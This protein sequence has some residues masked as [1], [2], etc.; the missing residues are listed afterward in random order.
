M[1]G[2]W[3]PKL[4]AAFSSLR[5]HCQGGESFEIADWKNDFDSTY[6]TF[7]NTNALSN[8]ISKKNLF[9]PLEIFSSSVLLNEIFR[10]CLH[11]SVTKK[12]TEKNTKKNKRQNKLFWTDKNTKSKEKDL[13]LLRLNQQTKIFAESSN[14]KI[15]K[16]SQK[17]IF[18]FALRGILCF[19]F[20]SLN[21]LYE[22]EK[23][24]QQFY[25]V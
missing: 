8:S 19:L 9:F 4:P 25:P 22:K 7:M 16:K 2:N 14:L 12:A 20:Y 24:I 3:Y 10:I 11:I 21:L 23:K 5:P 15:K 6:F 18:L 13:E 1:N 17:S